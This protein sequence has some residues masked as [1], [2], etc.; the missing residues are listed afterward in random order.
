MHIAWQSARVAIPGPGDSACPSHL[1]GAVPEPH[2]G[3][4]MP[5]VDVVVVVVVVVEVD[6]VPVEVEDLS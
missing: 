6:V 3:M 5:G 2:C 1:P 4:L